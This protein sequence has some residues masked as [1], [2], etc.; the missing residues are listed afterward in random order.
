MTEGKLLKLLS[1]IVSLS[2]VCII[3]QP[4]P[5]CL[6]IDRLSVGCDVPHT[7]TKSSGP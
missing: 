7:N 4:L 6:N 2:K 5:V 1:Y 3:L